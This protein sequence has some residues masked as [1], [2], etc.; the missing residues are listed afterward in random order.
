[1]LLRVLVLNLL[2][3]LAFSTA[4]QQNDQCSICGQGVSIESYNYT[5]QF[6]N[7]DE[8]TTRDVLI[9][10][11]TC[12]KVE[13]DASSGSF[14]NATCYIIQEAAQATLDCNCGQFEPPTA[15]QNPPTAP[16][17]PQDLPTAPTT[18]PPASST[19][20]GAIVGYSIAGVVFVATTASCL[21]A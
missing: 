15:I 6:H 2:I 19:A 8:N 20:V 7:L 9:N 4:Q 1:M 10:G 14:Y 11:Y 5:T 12:S 16:S 3:L 18:A 13:Q 21:L 17:P